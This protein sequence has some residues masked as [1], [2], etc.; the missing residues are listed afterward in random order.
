MC[1]IAGIFNTK[2]SPVDATALAAMTQAL[3]HRGPDDSGLW[4]AEGIGLGHRRLSII[5]LAG[6]HQPMLDP[7]GRFC[8]VFNGEIYNFRELRAELE[9]QGIAFQTRSDTEVLLQLF[10]R[11]G[12]EM[13]SRLHGMFAFAI[14]DTQRRR[15]FLARDRFGKKPLVYFFR[16]GCLAFASELQAL[17]HAPD[18]PT[19]V[20]LQS[21]HDYF[22]YQYVP[23]PDTIY[24]GVRKLLPGSFLVVD[25]GAATEPVPQAYW[26]LRFSPDQGA[27]FADS[28][29]YV[30]YRLQEAVTDRLVADVPLGAFLSGGVDS[31]CIAGL[32][33]QCGR[34]RVKTFTIG[35]GDPAY[36]ERAYARLAAEAL[37]TE[38]TEREVE[39][40]DFAV[41]RQL[42]RHC[43]E[44]FADAS[45]LP[46]YLLCRSTREHVTVAL[47]GDGADEVFGG[48][49]RYRA[50]RLARSLDAFPLPVRR[51]LVS[52]LVAMLP[53]GGHER[54]AGAR[55]RRLL[56]LLAE[57]P[58]QR[59]FQLVNKLAAPLR[60]RLLG[61]RFRDASLAAPEAFLATWFRQVT[62]PEADGAA[63]EVDLHTYLLNDILTK[64]D[65]ASMAASLEVRCPFLDHRV[66]EAAARLPWRFKQQGRARKRILDAAC[67]DLLPAPIRRRS[68]KGFGVPLAAWFRGAWQPMLRD[69]LLDP[70][71]R[72][73]G[74]FAPETVEGL[75]QAHAAGAAD[76]SYVLWSLL[77]FELWCQEFAVG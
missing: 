13:L 64:V 50:L 30:R 75:I 8:I 44:P 48:Y 43:G 57:A 45:I 42:V 28:A 41:V 55:L 10:R 62:T 3:T 23:S 6:G 4:Q 53:R 5:D 63:A 60:Q 15:I 74:F 12:P 31:T 59:Y 22:S 1:G 34:G 58:D 32:M 65:I 39:A 46:T 38:H 24:C 66:V 47:S 25:A 29:A 77:V 21:V 20:R 11:D 52:A 19:D 54:T 40:Q 14:Y 9:R 76:H 33:S 2:G 37:G 69:V 73:R 49:E 51:G 36:D 35:F 61:P 70:A 16:N 67:R 17:R 7:D 56:Q 68:K 71:C 18:C 72:A 26:S 27:S